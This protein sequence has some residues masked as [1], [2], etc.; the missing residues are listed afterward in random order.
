MNISTHIDS[1]NGEPLLV[2]LNAPYQTIEDGS[3]YLK[4]QL[5]RKFCQDSGSAYAI[6]VGSQ[7][8]ASQYPGLLLFA[9]IDDNLP[10]WG[11]EAEDAIIYI[12][13]DNFIYSVEVGS[14]GACV[15]GTER[16]SSYEDHI[17]RQSS[18]KSFYLAGGALSDRFDDARAIDPLTDLRAYH[19]ATV[20]RECIRNQYFTA[21]HYVGVVAAMGLL[22]AITMFAADL[23]NTDPQPAILPDILLATPLGN[24]LAVSQFLS[25][26]DIIDQ[27]LQYFVSKGMTTFTYSIDGGVSV[28]GQYPAF[29]SLS[30]LAS[31]TE[32]ANVPLYFSAEGWSVHKYPSIPLRPQFELPPFNQVFLVMKNLEEKF[33]FQVAQDT[34]VSHLDRTTMKV[35]LQKELVAKPRLRELAREL[36]GWPV[37]INS[38]SIG[39]GSNQFQFISM[40]LTISG[41]KI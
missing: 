36:E 1:V 37:A 33:S 19:F 38:L 35:S 24:D 20:N 5:L 30:E 40:T 11:L 31:D 14:L 8:W 41:E 26:A 34:A 2:V 15:V 16:I 28:A 18:L 7:V 39:F 12:P 22:T 9:Y 3:S 10:Q 32:R 17:H 13:L 25:L 23:M 29:N 4:G 21:P 6:V 27:D